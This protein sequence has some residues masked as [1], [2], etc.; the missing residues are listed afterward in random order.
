MRNLEE[1]TLVQILISGDAEDMALAVTKNAGLDGLV[2]Q[3]QR[4][5]MTY[6]KIHETMATQDTS[7]LC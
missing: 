4:Q 6:W 1:V 5:S 3:K 2:N 7:W